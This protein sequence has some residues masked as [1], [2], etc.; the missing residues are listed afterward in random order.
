M[1]AELAFA[2]ATEVAGLIRS[3]KASIPE[4]V[5]MFYQRIDELNPKLIAY[6]A[7]CPE[8]AAK[9]ANA[10]Q[11]VVQKGGLHFCI[12]GVEEQGNTGPAPNTRHE[13]SEVLAPIA[14]GVIPLVPISRWRRLADG[15]RV[16]VERRHCTVALDGE[17]AFSLNPSQQLEVAVHRDGP[18]VVHVDVAL[19][20]A[21]SLGLFR[22]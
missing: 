2:P 14:P 4:L 3:K 12:G 5:E 1:E 19:Q 6:L 17:R 8:Q 22:V 16:A 11:E 10:A 9:Q 18:P 15:E 20:E 13:A 21:A 7:L